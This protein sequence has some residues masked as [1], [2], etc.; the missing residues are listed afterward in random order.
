MTSAL[1]GGEWSAARPGHT[2]PPG[3]TPI[4]IV[5]EAD[6]AA[7]PVWTGAKTVAPTGI[8]YPDRPARSQSL[9]RLIYL[10]HFPI[11]IYIELSQKTS[12]YPTI[13][14][15][16]YFYSLQVTTLKLRAREYGDTKRTSGHRRQRNPPV[17]GGHYVRIPWI[18]IIRTRYLILLKW[19]NRG[20]Q[21][22]GI[23]MYKKS[24]LR[25]LTK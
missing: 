23:R 20:R 2:L 4:P 3:K 14:H 1:E 9:Y 7:G 24:G 6:W 19:P 21:Q 17:A 18:S 10:A 16:N 22:T 11:Y 15:E 5:Q 12:L 13:K 25:S 8:R